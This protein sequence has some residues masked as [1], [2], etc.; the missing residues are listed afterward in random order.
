MLKKV[1]TADATETFLNESVGETYHS[2][3]G[4]VEEALKKYAVPCK[5]AEKAKSGHIRI[6][7]ICSGLG[8]NSAMAIDVA[9]KTNPDCVIE[10]VGL[11]YDTE[12]IA[13]IQDVNP[14]ITFF[15]HY[16]KLTPEITELKEGNVT[17]TFIIGD[18]RKTITELQENH[19]DA[20]FFDPF[21]P[22]TA[23]HMWETLFFKDV[24][25]VMKESGIMATYSCA[26]I[27]RDNMSKAGL[28]YDDGPIVG[29]R[30]PG[31]IATKWI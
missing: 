11:E 3:T 29:R 4:A 5:I 26:R 12:I 18:A 2:Q 28:F 25:R 22:K 23:P 30:G 31:T 21:S 14:P 24:H 10:V 6:L 17:V 16:K 15:T 7:D 13:K 19:F 1:T 27:A 8:Y 20:V 9:L